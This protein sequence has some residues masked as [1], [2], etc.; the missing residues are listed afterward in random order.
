M[1]NSKLKV[2]MKVKM[3]VDNFIQLRIMDKN[4]IEIIYHISDYFI[5]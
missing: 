4:I 1:K 3:I 5:R 2:N